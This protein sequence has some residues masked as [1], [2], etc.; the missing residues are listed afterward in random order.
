[1]PRSFDHPGAGGA[2][3]WGGGPWAFRDPDRSWGPSRRLRLWVP[4]FLSA[5][6][7]IPAAVWLVKVTDPDFAVAVAT[8][9][10]AVVGPVA[11]IGARRFPGP[12]A[13]VATAAALGS[14]LVGAGGGPP[15][16]ALA[17]AL[18]GAIVR[19]A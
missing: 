3:H 12:V 7:Q 2:E 15:P 5:V 13:A 14:L 11:L 8:V 18:I 1:M 9:S 4:V 17:F 16:I 6:I 19:G 10:L